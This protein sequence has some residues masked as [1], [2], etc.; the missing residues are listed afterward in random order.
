MINVL[1]EIESFLRYHELSWKDVIC[2]DIIKDNGWSEV[3][4]LQLGL[5]YTSEDLEHFKSEAYLIDYTEHSHQKLFGN[6]WL[7]KNRWIE[8]VFSIYEVSSRW[9]LKQMPEIPFS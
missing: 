3:D 9:E 8:R 7:T 5:N 1:D 4:R 6:V 2:A